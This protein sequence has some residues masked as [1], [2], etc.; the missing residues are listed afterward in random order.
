MLFP[1]WSAIQTLQTQ[2]KIV[3]ST[4]SRDLSSVSKQW[5]TRSAW[6][7]LFFKVGKTKTKKLCLWLPRWK[8]REKGGKKKCTI[9]PW[10]LN[11]R[12]VKRNSG[13]PGCWMSSKHAIGKAPN[14]F[15]RRLL[16]K[17][18][19]GAVR[20][21]SACLVAT[22]HTQLKGGAYRDLVKS[23]TFAWLMLL[24]RTVGNWLP[25][26]LLQWHRDA[27]V[28]LSDR[29]LPCKKQLEMLRL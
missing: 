9:M 24:Q 3:M 21:I 25:M 22:T 20:L 5:N 4:T 23:N 26:D 10:A 28:Q 11:T 18:S 13:F 29:M 14:S 27:A 12:L 8:G 6:M 7:S 17:T 19:P 16:P 1:L 15:Q 2:H